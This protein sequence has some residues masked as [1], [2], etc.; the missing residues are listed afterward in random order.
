MCGIAGYFD[1]NESPDASLINRMLTRIR[2]RGPDECGIYIGENI[3]FGSVRL[4]IIDIHGG[5]QPLPNE[6][7]TLWIAFNGEIFN[8]IEL[9]K[10]LEE[11]GH[12]FRTYSDTEV[13]VH[14]YEEYGESCLPKLNGQFAFSIWDKNKQEMFLARDRVGIRPLFYYNTPDLFVYGSEIKAI[15][16]HPKVG[17]EISFEGLAETFTFWT[18]ITPNTVFKGIRECPPGHF[19]KIKDGE[20][21]VQKFWELN[22]ATPNNYYKGSFED[23]I[24][25]F[26]ELFKDSVRIRLRADVPVAAYLSGGLDSSVTTAFIKDIE[27]NVLKTFSVGFKEDEFDESN[28]Q[29]L[30]SKYFNTNHLGFECSSKEIADNFPQV[31]WH[32]E[33]PLLR[34]SPSPMYS[35]SKKVME[36]NIKVV[37]TGEGADELLAGY[38]IFK[39]NKIRHFWS[40]DKNSR[41]RPLLLKKLYPYISSLQ[42][43][44]YNALK[45]FFGYKLDETDSP[46]YSHLLRWKNSSNITKHFSK[47]IQEKLKSFDPYLKLFSNFDG[48]LDKLDPLAKSQF[49][50]ISVFLSGYLL[51]SQGDR[52]GMAN[53]V[54]GRYPF[55]D[56]RIIEFCASLPPDYKL[57]GLNEKVLLKKMMI[58]RLPEEILN[59]PKQ[60]YRAPILSSFLGVDAPDYIKEVLSVESLLNAGIFS[61][62]SVSKLLVKMNSGKSYSEIDNMALTAVIS[63]QLL[64]KQFINDFKHLNNNDLINCNVRSESN[65][66]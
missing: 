2:H 21:K 12:H 48:K 46:V 18:T 3:G 4:S 1:K 30:A 49:I 52:M 9:R 14:L 38:D 7:L 63:T 25:D 51:S 36:N 10:E 20:L 42:N 6:D 29:N 44:N 53:S 32:S 22:F 26:S 57:K 13:L 47:E 50:E 40:K 55:L 39:E 5:Q 33:I 34:T 24:S 56:Y 64:Y 31:V 58:G 65:Y 11:K 23:A 41:I 61:V 8:Y 16:E 35:L 28:F 17:R 43:A 19:M 37:I 62:N 27:P 45:M 15:F 59:R 60:A 54:E 66:N